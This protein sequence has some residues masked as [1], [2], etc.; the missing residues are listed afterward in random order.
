MVKI[1]LRIYSVFLALL[2]CLS[3]SKIEEAGPKV[4]APLR[5]YTITSRLDNKQAGTDSQATGVL[6][7]TYSEVTK[8]LVYSLEFSVPEPLS[9]R[10]DKGAKGAVGVWVSEFAKNAGHAYKSPI[11]GQKKLTSL[12]ERDLLKGIW[13]ISVETSNYKPS[14][15]RGMVTVKL[16]K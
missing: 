3:C 2:C 9:V 6:K 4:K 12:E 16:S 15:I 5:S 11:T 13:Y 8:L 10:I 7:G 1:T 14:E